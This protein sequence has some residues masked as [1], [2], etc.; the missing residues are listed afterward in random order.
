MIVRTWHGRTR[1][2]DAAAYETFTIDRAGKDYSSVP[3]FKKLYFTRRDE[4]DVAHFLLITIWDS[5]EAVE[6]FAGKDASKAKYYPEDGGF[7]LEKEAHSLN[8]TLFFER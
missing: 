6:R 1:L 3:G 2:K 4:G 8:H 7:L 5:L